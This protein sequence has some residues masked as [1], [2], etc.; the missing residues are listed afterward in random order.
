MQ[1]NKLKILLTGGS[2]G[3][4]KAILERFSDHDVY[5]PSRN[6][7]DLSKEINLKVVDFD[8]V[9]NNAGI[10]PLKSI[11]NVEDD[12]VMRVNYHAPLRIVQQCLPF[13]VYQRFGRIV[14]I[15]SIWIDL[16][17]HDRLSYSASKA[18]LHSLTR[19]LTA[20]YASYGILSNTVSP[21]FVKTD[22]TFA[23]N[24][25]KDLR[26]TICNIPLNRLCEPREIAN[27][28]YYLCVENTYMSGQNIVVDGGFTC[29]A[30]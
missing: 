24:T 12:M 18:A 16:A 5:A 3:I 1:R 7:L 21:G 15:G 8:V 13:M 28:V 22:L 27:I 9:I 17:K 2:R 14:N 6:E 25:E 26:T 30:N 4:G 19:S 23:N 29:T 20:E 10:N 11:E